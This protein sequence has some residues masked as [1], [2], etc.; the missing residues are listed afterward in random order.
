MS[1]CCSLREV[2]G[3]RYISSFLDVFYVEVRNKTP[4]SPAAVVGGGRG[5][6]RFETGSRVTIDLVHRG[7]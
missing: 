1:E 6:G 3:D 7:C 5:E 2:K 4:L